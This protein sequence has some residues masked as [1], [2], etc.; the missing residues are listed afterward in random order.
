MFDA[1]NEFT[2]NQDRDKDVER[3]DLELENESLELDIRLK[4]GEFFKSEDLE[5]HPKLY[6]E[7]LR[8][9]LEYE[10]LE[11]EYV[12][13]RPLSC[14]FPDDFTFPPV[15]ELESGRLEEK[16][17]AIEEVL[18][19]NNI[20]LA[21]ADKLPAKLVYKYLTEEVLLE[22]AGFP[23]GPDCP[24][25]CVIDGCEGYCPGCFQKDYCESSAIWDLED[26]LE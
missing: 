7:F 1:Q 15:D 23:I 19:S 14:L 10:S 17:T 25:I 20:E 5:D 3:L 6:N 26:S 9:V 2:D 12:D 21:L 4:G 8:N 16:L 22:P 11:E 18:A 13:D 24:S